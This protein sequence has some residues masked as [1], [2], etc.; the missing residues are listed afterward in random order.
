MKPPENGLLT[1]TSKPDETIDK[2]SNGEPSIPHHLLP[3]HLRPAKQ[4][5]VA[6]TSTTPII[7]CAKDASSIVEAS[8][9][10]PVAQPSLKGKSKVL[11]E[12][13]AAVETNSNVKT[14]SNGAQ[15]SRL[16]SPLKKLDSKPKEEG[17]AQPVVPAHPLLNAW[18]GSR[19][20]PPEDWEY[21]TQELIPK[22]EHKATFQSWLDGQSSEH[23]TNESIVDITSQEFILG[24]GVVHDNSIVSGYVVS[25]P[26][27]PFG[28]YLND[29]PRAKS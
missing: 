8:S 16:P 7:D 21:R 6:P 2:T 19:A 12:N 4:K 27:S 10:K 20:N 26:S 29:Y 22:K 13:G 28:A 23:V 15:T 1:K 5:K 17:W 14:A 3:P 11:P 25:D 18:D 24:T 9:L